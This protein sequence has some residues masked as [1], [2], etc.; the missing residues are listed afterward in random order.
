MHPL[1]LLDPIRVSRASRC[2]VLYLSY[3]L[4]VVDLV[5]PAWVR[6]RIADAE[7][8]YSNRDLGESFVIQR[9]G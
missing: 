7:R 4:V 2:V 8:D 3:C 9:N 6:V 5:L 1:Y